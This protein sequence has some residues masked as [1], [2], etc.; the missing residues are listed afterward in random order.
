MRFVVAVSQELLVKLG[1]RVAAER[2][3]EHAWLAT[4]REAALRGPTNPA[5]RAR[6]SSAIRVELARLRATGRLLGS[7]DALL[8]WEVQGVLADRGWARDWPA[9]PAGA[10]SAPGRRW[11]VSPADKRGGPAR[12]AVQLPDALGETVRRVAFWCSAD[13]VGELEEW[14]GLTAIEPHGAT[15]E[16]RTTDP[17]VLLAALSPKPLPK[18]EVTLRARAKIVTVGDILRA[19]AQRAAYPQA[20]DSN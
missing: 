1:K 14:L 20:T 8:T 12:L 11:G 2:D 3:R 10:A 19:A 15:R 16:I 13:A 9:P 7:R 5:E 17:A 6:A 18:V 4:T